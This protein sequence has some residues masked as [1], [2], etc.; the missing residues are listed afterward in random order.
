MKFPPCLRFTAPET[1][2]GLRPRIAL[3]SAQVNNQG[4]GIENIKQGQRKTVSQI[5]HTKQRR[6]KKSFASSQTHN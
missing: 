1:A 2:L 5:T 3:S 6:G 4:T